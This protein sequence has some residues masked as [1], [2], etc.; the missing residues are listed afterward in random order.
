[1][2]WPTQDPSWDR[3]LTIL[4]F[5]W[6]NYIPGYAR[7]NFSPFIILPL[8]GESQDGRA[9]GSLSA[10]ISSTF[11][12][13]FFWCDFVVETMKYVTLRI[14]LDVLHVRRQAIDATTMIYYV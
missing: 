8:S 7:A 12:G 14:C 4:G 10:Y 9:A 3:G 11:Q 1:M 5:Q 13:R 6:P 2:S